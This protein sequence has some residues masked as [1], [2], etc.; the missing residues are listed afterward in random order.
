MWLLAFLLVA[1]TTH[2][3][4]L[5]VA[6]AESLWI[7]ISGSGEPVVLVPGLFGSGYGYRKL[8]PLL[9]DAGY[10]TIIIE[11]LGV[12]QSARPE[13][14]DYSLGAQ[15]DRI[16]AALDTLRISDAL[17]VAHSVGA[18]IVFRLAYKRPDLIRAVISLDGG[19]A[20]SA[21]TAGFRRAMRFAPLIRLFG[22]VKLI[23]GKIRRHMLAASGDASWVNDEVVQGYTA[24]A[25]D[26]V[27]ATI[28]AY[29][30]MARAEEREPLEPHLG[31]IRCP[32]L[33]LVGGVPH[34]G[35]IRPEEVTL[36]ADGVPAFSVDTI[37]AVGHFLH[38][39]APQVV[40]HAVNR[41]R[42]TVAVSHDELR[43]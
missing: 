25:V 1:D 10:Q 23:R 17:V 27:G 9:N 7:S 33:L 28:R 8:G 15:S 4:S 2:G 31:E 29:R 20:E 12:G 42:T 11:P 22:G 36:L 32:V 5:P 6:P 35:A 43:N 39:E 37:P 30:A 41:M 3:L 40:V 24:A 34:D 14:A 19:P 18:A 38:E 21:T 13:D 16:A 26:D